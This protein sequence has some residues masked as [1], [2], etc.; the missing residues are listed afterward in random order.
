M[1]YPRLM[2]AFL[3]I[4]CISAI[5]CNQP[6]PTDQ[7]DQSLKMQAALDTI[8]KDAELA[9]A[10]NAKQEELL[11]SIRDEVVGLRGD[12]VPVP[13]PEPQKTSTAELDEFDVFIPDD[14]DTPEEKPYELT[15]EY[16]QLV[17]DLVVSTFDEVKDSTPPQLFLPPVTDQYAAEPRVRLL[18]YGAK[19]CA[20]CLV[21]DRDQLPS[22]DNSLV[23]EVVSYD[24]DQNT[25]QFQNANVTVMPT[26]EIEIDG[27]VVDRI[28]ST[29]GVT[30]PTAAFV[31]GRIRSALNGEKPVST[32]SMIKSPVYSTSTYS[33]P[34]FT[35]QVYTRSYSTFQTSQ[36]STQP[37]QRY[38]MKVRSR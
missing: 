4:A 38:R 33:A 7:L 9:S 21:W 26:W 20:G 17:R 34:V 14:D 36:P 13:V 32:Q 5:G 18:K 2:L 27:K 37:T 10:S 29:V 3:I 16:K 23:D 19:W 25:Q 12:L 22:I 8:A 31:N 24:Y 1:R 11:L 15:E 6:K 28:E 30:P 35:P